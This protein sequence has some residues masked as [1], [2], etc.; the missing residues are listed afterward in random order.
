MPSTI[1]KCKLFG[2]NH[3]T[4]LEGETNTNFFGG[5]EN[6][7]RHLSWYIHE[8]FEKRQHQKVPLLLVTKLSNLVAVAEL[9]VHN[10][11]GHQFVLAY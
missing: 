11:N 10:A 5:K 9:A 2:I 4:L 6:I 8:I 7:K 3:T 1:G